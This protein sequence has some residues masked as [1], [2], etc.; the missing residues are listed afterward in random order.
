MINRWFRIDD[1]TY[2][3]AAFTHFKCHTN[4]SSIG[5]AYAVRGYLAVPMTKTGTSL[6]QIPIDITSCDTDEDGNAIIAG[7]LAGQYDVHV[8]MPGV[9]PYNSEY[10]TFI[11]EEDR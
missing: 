11:R 1:V 5:G 7:I 8:K 3:L 6:K 10:A 2:N 9:A 4:P